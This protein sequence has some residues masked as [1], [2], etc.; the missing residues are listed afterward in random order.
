MVVRCRKRFLLMRDTASISAQHA[1]SVP[2][3][4]FKV[5]LALPRFQSIGFSFFAHYEPQL[6]R[7]ANAAAQN[8]CL[9]LFV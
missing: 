7:P 3:E 5:T 6:L 4:L 8:D 2:A 9:R 1:S